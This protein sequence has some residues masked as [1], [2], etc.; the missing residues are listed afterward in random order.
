MNPTPTE[1]QETGRDRTV[2]RGVFVRR[3]VRQVEERRYVFRP[4][5]RGWTPANWREQTRWRE[6]GPSRRP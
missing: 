5:S 4:V 2:T 6:C 1:W 3:Q